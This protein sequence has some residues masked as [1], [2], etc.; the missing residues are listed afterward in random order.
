MTILRLYWGLLTDDVISLERVQDFLTIEHEPARTGYGKPPAYWPASGSLHVENLSAKYSADGPEVLKKVSFSL[1]SGERMGV[2]GRTG[3]GKSTI[4]LALLRAIPTS[5]HVVYDGIDVSKLNLDALRSNIT[6]I[7]QHPELLAGTLR[8]NLDPFEEHDD[9]SLND[10]LRSAGLYHT[11]AEGEDG[12]INLDTEVRG[13][14]SNLSQGQ[15][16]IIDLARAILRRSKIVILDEAT[17]AI[18]Q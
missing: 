11:Q 8:E 17:A 4:A 7:P 12:S 16:Q 3:A 15:R 10:A 5:G 2:V 1:K 6:I 13:G 14:G 18:G 9:V